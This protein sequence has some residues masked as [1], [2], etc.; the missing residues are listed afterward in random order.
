MA[1][2]ISITASAAIIWHILR[3]YDGL[4][5]TYHRLVLG[6]CIA[7]IVF[8]ICHCL[9]QYEVPKE[10]E[11]VMPS[12]QG[13][14]ASCDTQ[15]FILT[16][17]AVAASLYNCSMC[18]YYLAVIKYNKRDAYIRNKLEPWFHGISY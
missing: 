9:I 12:A 17:G 10:L 8:F 6:L 4:S 1:G 5:T 11:Y 7:D 14:V 18:V 3:S 15:G 13:N 2:S 16:I